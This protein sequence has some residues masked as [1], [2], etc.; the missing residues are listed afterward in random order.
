MTSKVKIMLACVAALVIGYF[1]GREHLKYKMRTAMQDAFNELQSGLSTA[2]GGGK[3]TPTPKQVPETPTKQPLTV[4]LI[5]KG[6]IPKN[7]HHGKF[8][9]ELTF[10]LTF[11][12]KAGK[13]IRAF[14]GLLEFT[15]LLDN[16]I[17]VS[18][19]EINERVGQDGVLS[20]EGALDYRA[21][22]RTP[23]TAW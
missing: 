19:I 13:D 22:P 15:D 9:E 2:L 10:T 16:R 20:W 7:I 23:G 8:D 14:D 12:N 11:E 18:K 6:F 21:H 3:D 17:V 1:V 4:T 5:K